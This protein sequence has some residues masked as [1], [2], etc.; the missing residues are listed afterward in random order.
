MIEKIAIVLMSVGIVVFSGLSAWYYFGMDR[1]A[2]TIRFAEATITYKEGEDMSTLL[3]GLSAVDNR[4]GNV[5]DNVRVDDIMV[6][7]DMKSAVVVY[8]VYDKSYNVSKAKR[9]VNYEAKKR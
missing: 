7:D 1:V 4:D 2:P 6:A 9:T 5:T 3:E 8:A